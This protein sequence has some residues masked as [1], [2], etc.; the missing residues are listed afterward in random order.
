MTALREEQAKSAPVRVS[1]EAVAALRPLTEAAGED[2]ARRLTADSSR[3]QQVR[4]QLERRLGWRYPWGEVVGRPA[5]QGVSELKRR[6]DDA[7]R[8][9]K[10]PLLKPVLR[11][12]ERPAFLQDA[13]PGLTP[14]ERGSA[15]HLVMQH[16]DLA[17]PLDEEDIARQI[18]AMVEKQMLTPDQAAAVDVPPI[19]RFFDGRWV[20]GC[21]AD[22]GR[23]RREV[24]FTMALPAA[25]GIPR[26]GSAS[27]GGSRRNRR[28]AGHYRLSAPGRRCAAHRR[29]QDGSGV[30]GAGRASARKRTGRKWG[31]I[32]GRCR[33]STAWPGWKRISCS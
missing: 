26:S 12:E 13:A 11:L 1:W 33:P 31:C 19:A 6:W 32:A 10:A 5:K 25:G 2:G 20:A 24:P 4:G 18:E 23:V 28:G 7:D 15:V 14:T 27:G 29:L 3:F 8:D 16:L 30:G 21:R 9:E 22:A 17:G